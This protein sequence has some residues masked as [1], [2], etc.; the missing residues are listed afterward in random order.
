MARRSRVL[1]VVV[2]VVVLISD[3]LK[4][5]CP[6]FWHIVVAQLRRRYFFPLLGSF[7]GRLVGELC[8]CHYL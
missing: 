3:F 1:V 5:L 6:Y 8:Q 7:R 2:V 4:Y